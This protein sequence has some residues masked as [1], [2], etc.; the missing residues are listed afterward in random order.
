METY[1]DFFLTSEKCLRRQTYFSLVTV[2][3]YVRR[4][5]LRRA[6]RMK[7]KMKEFYFVNMSKYTEVNFFLLVK[8]SQT[9]LSCLQKSDS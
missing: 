9:Y 3:A 7:T 4:A 8:Q 5:K 6:N 1:R 2:Y